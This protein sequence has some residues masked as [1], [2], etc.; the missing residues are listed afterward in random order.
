MHAKLEIT[1]RPLSVALPASRPTRKTDRSL[2]F[3]KGP[4]PAVTRALP[5]CTKP[6]RKALPA[7]EMAAREERRGGQTARS[8][9]RHPAAVVRL[10][11]MNRLAT[12]E[13]AVMVLVF[14]FVVAV[15]AH[16]FLTVFGL[17]DLLEKLNQLVHHAIQ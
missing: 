6:Y 4:R 10:S 17:G 11:E 14:F 16:H 2:G 13:T 8:P 1:Q 12:T 3:N 9:G 5:R 15:V 7:V